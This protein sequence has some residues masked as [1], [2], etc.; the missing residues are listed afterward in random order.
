M[1]KKQKQMIVILS[2]V[3]LFSLSELFPPFSY[4]D[5]HS[6]QR[7]AGYH[8]FY[9]PPT[10]VKIPNEMSNAYSHPDEQF[11]HFRVGR[12]IIRLLG[13]RI[14]LL[15]AML[16]LLLLLEERRSTLKAVFGVI[17]LCLCFG[18]LGLYSLYVLAIG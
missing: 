5:E 3:A 7:S 18:V 4:K 9:D 13:Q 10:T 17:S 11:R 14:I 8:F 15:L 2:A 16:G 6:R 1:N 12:D